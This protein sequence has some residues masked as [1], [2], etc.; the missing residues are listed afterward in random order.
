MPKRITKLDLDPVVRRINAIAGH[1][2]DAQPYDENHQPVPRVYYLYGAYNGYRLTQMAANGTGE[3]DPMHTG[4][5]KPKEL[6]PI[7][8]AFAAGMIAGKEL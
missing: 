7:L 5:L 6:L 1:G 2:E 3:T 4:F 8:H